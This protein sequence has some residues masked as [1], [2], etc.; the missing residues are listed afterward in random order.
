MTGKDEIF[1]TPIDLFH[2][3]C[4]YCGT[5]LSDYSVIEVS[6]LVHRER[7]KTLPSENCFA[8]SGV[9]VLGWGRSVDD[10]GAH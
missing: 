1:S 6:L 7:R 10:R 4:L 3:F 2:V 9:A 5:M 8:L